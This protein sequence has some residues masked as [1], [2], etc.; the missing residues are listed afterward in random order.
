M[1]LLIKE[2]FSK[3]KN[4]LKTLDVLAI[5]E[6]ISLIALNLIEKYSKSYGLEIP[7]ALIASTSIYYNAPLLTHNKKDFRY[8]ENLK[9]L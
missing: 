6:E 9:L 4:F 7:D 2:R 8:L 3:I 5:N 1:E